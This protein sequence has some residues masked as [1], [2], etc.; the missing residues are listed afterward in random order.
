MISDLPRAALAVGSRCVA[1]A[2]GAGGELGWDGICARYSST[3]ARARAD[4]AAAR[5]SSDA[6]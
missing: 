3:S 1:G 4:S 5:A 2:C 6:P